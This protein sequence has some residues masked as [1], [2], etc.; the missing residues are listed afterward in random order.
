MPA[1]VES[2]VHR[3]HPISGVETMSKDTEQAHFGADNL[4]LKLKVDSGRVSTAS[5]WLT[6]QGMRI[7]SS[8]VIDV[9]G[10]VRLHGSRNGESVA[11]QDLL[12]V[13]THE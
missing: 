11:V 4:A 8:S 5:P 7:F 6:L 3:Q 2:K 1:S 12:N 9:D 10:N 13:F